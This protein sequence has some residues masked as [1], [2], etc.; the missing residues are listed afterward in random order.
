MVEGALIW[1][2][3]HQNFA[4][5]KI[6]TFTLAWLLAICISPSL[7]AQNFDVYVSDAG[8]F[9][10]PGNWQILKFDENGENGQVFISDHL[11]WPQDIFFIE[12]N[13][14]VLISNLNT[15]TLSKFDATTGAFLEEFATGI[16]GPTRMKLGPDSLLYVLQWSPNTRV[17]RYQLNGTFVD[18]FTKTN[19]GSAIGLDWDAEGNLF[20]ASYNGNYVRKYSPNG[21]D[22]G[23]F[24]SS[25]LN[26]PTNIWF[27][28]EGDLFV[29]NWNNGIVKR[30][31]GLGNFVE[32][33]ITGAPNCEGV[34]FFPN[35]DIAIGV[36]G[37]SSVKV[38]SPD[39]AFIKDLVAPGTLNLLV[40]NAVVFRGKTASKTKDKYLEM[41]FVSPTIGSHFQISNPDFAGRSLSCEVF[42]T[43]GLFVQKMEFSGQTIWDASSLANGIYYLTVKLPDGTMARQKVV[44]QR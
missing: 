3:F 39:G 24:I 43:S 13:N 21:D 23:N 29:N 12:S 35:G 30:F 25:G 41:S 10:L 9:N 6:K 36:G 44:V 4:Y 42:D 18:D 40:P 34:D 27:N 7:F 28:D 31:D 2:L 26:G 8:N 33:F 20:V 14:T 38:Y 19:T 11:A 22:L 32:D 37:T 5:M 17:K 15:G 1:P 16:S